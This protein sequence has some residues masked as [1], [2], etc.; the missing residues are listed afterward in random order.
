[1]LPRVS[2]TFALN[3]RVLPGSLRDVVGQAYLFC[4]IADTVEDSPFLSPQEKAARLQSFADLFPM[5]EG[6]ASRV[7][8][9]SQAFEALRTRGDEYALC[10]NSE[11]VF[12]AFGASPPAL[13]A[14]V[15]DCVREMAT[16]MR[17]FSC[18]RAAAADGRLQLE[19]TADLERYCYVVAGTV[20]NMLVRLF[21]ASS[22]HIDVARAQRLG[23]LSARFGLALQ[24]TN[25]IKDVAT[26][27]R[28]GACYVP[29][30]WAARYGIEPRSVLEPACR[31]AARAVVRDLAQHAVGA[32]DAALAF[33]LEM[34][35]REL[36]LRLFCL[37]P[38]FLAIR[39]L[40]RVLPDEH[41]FVPGQRP[42]VT[43]DEVRRCIGETAL[44]ACSNGA[45]RRLYGRRRL[46]LEAM[47]F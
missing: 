25:I 9:W 24:L 2:R 38:L 44:A 18:R 35:R 12:L 43:R 45:I 33:T 29:R 15:E 27:V 21:S 10:R 34:P 41:M 40:A 26:D 19:D 16:G 5:L 32:L 17:D 36:R 31:K 1:M 46:A 37:W 47:G 39:T 20:G 30:A 8:R 11:R 14:P 42:R 23:A 22:R 28:R 7:A 3:I 6:D 4:R 13:R